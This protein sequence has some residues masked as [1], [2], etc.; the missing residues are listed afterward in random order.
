[1]GGD[2][3]NVGT[4]AIWYSQRTLTGWIT[5]IPLSTG[6]LDSEFAEAVIIHG[7]QLHIV[8]NDFIE[9]DIF[10]VTCALNAPAVAPGILL[11][12]TPTVL[13]VLP[14]ESVVDSAVS[15]SPELP[16]AS[17]ASEPSV[18]TSQSPLMPLLLGVTPVLLLVGFVLMRRQYHAH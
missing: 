10:Y 16:I 4:T 7:N 9:D 14:P 12:P 1:M 18:Q 3:R 5:P 6:L 11:S 15:E 13:P 8:W 17:V 2:V